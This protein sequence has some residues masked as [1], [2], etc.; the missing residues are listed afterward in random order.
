MLDNTANICRNKIS[1][2]LLTDKN[3]TD[4]YFLKLAKVDL[5]ATS[6]YNKL[7]SPSVLRKTV[8][9]IEKEQDN[10]S[11]TKSTPLVDKS[12][13]L[14]TVKTEHRFQKET[15]QSAE[16]PKSESFQKASEFWN[17]KNT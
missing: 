17:R 2:N 1:E 7:P 12:K 9:T 16:K 6:L 5:P 13:I 10:R 4:Q 8:S 14:A 3:K 11:C 15:I